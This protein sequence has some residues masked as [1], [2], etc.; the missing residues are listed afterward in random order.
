MKDRCVDVLQVD[1]VLCWKQSK[2]V[3][4]TVLDYDFESTA[5]HPHRVALLLVLAS[6]ILKR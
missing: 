4:F 1:A 2:V 3:G 5:G 6:M